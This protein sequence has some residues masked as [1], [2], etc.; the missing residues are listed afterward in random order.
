MVENSQMFLGFLLPCSVFG[1]EPVQICCI[2]TFHGFPCLSMFANALPW[3]D[4]FVARVQLG[5]L[6]WGEFPV[7]QLRYLVKQEPIKQLAGGIYNPISSMHEMDVSKNR[8]T[9]KSPILRVFHYKPSI[10]GYHHFR[11]PP[12]IYLHFF[13]N[14]FSHVF[15][16]MIFCCQKFT[17]KS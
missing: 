9:P 5:V 6:S 3:C 16:G 11:K 10:L 15:W 7:I 14:F 2:W 8:G 13:H 17:E 12:N 4:W 1:L